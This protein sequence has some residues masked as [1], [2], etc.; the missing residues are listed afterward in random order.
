MKSILFSFVLVLVASVVVA[1]PPTE[2]LKIKTS[3]KCDMCKE[4]IE[5]NLTLTKGIKEAVL[6]L[7]TKVVTISYNPKKIKPADIKSVIIKTGYDADDI[8]ADD[9]AHDKLPECCQKSAEAH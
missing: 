5:K 9:K 2:T 3:A 8:M 7:D 6:D 1:L 4:R